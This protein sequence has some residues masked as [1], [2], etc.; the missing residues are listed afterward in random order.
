MDLT[1]AG[2]MKQ[3]PLGDRA[4]RHHHTESV[5]KTPLKPHQNECW[6]IAPKENAAFVANMDE[7]PV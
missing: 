2:G 7:Q 4:V 3:G 6:C 1:V 5:K